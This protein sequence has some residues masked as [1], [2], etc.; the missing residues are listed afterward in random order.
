MAK[1]IH[2]RDGKPY[3]EYKLKAGTL[4]IGR[5][6]DCSI[7]LL[8]DVTVSGNHAKVFISPNDYLEGLFD[9]VIEDQRSTNGTL[10]NDKKIKRHRWKHGEQIKIGSHEFTLIDE[11]TRAF[12][13]T[14]ILLPDK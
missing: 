1:I 4:T 10:L 2:T 5:R 11:Q 14:N 8:D 7:Q 9:V 13:Q 3:K 12:E 6:P